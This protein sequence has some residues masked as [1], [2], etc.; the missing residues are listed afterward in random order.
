M[1]IETNLILDNRKANL[2]SCTRSENLINRK[3][4]NNNTSGY[5]GVVWNKQRGKWLAQI[6][7]N[8]RH[9]YLGSFENPVDAQVEYQKALI[10][11]YGAF[12]Q[13]NNK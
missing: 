12:L 8:K 5:T 11:Y 1:L 7:V 13:L 2:R 6:N 3:M 4:M 10:K 9:I